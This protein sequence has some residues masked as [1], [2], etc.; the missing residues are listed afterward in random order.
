MEF[1]LYEWVSLPS[2]LPPCCLLSSCLPL[3]TC[4]CG[5]PWCHHSSVLFRGEQGEEDIIWVSSDGRV[6]CGD[7]LGWRKDRASVPGASQLG[8]G[9]QHFT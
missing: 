2:P 4:L 9:G 6:R 1:H 3:P 5:R 7:V 8:G